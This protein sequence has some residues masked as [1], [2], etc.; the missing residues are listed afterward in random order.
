MRCDEN[1][2]GV[3]R[4]GLRQPGG[5]SPV[6]TGRTAIVAAAIVL[7]AGCGSSPLGPSAPRALLEITNF[8]MRYWR[9]DAAD[10]PVGFVYVYLPQVTLTE[11][12]GRTPAILDQLEFRMPNGERN[13]IGRGCMDEESQK[14]AASGTWD[15][16]KLY[17]YCQDLDTAFDVSGLPITLTVTYSDQYGI[18]GQLTSTVPAG[19]VR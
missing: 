12:S 11:R 3:Q 7:F 13:L 9:I 17:Y 2:G 4:V 10:P 19:P 15:M 18:S 1:A 14:V 8:E 6:K 16:T 5:R